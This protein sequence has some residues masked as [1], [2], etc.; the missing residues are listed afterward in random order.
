MNPYFTVT[1]QG[2]TVG[3]VLDLFTA[4]AKFAPALLL[5]DLAEGPV[6]AKIPVCR[7]DGSVYGYL[8]VREQG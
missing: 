4:D 3:G 8:F 1:S 2:V 5:E 7:P 6:I